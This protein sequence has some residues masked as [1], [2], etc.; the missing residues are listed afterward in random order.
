VLGI[1]TSRCIPA[2]KFSGWKI[3]GGIRETKSHG[4]E[5]E[6][7][8]SVIA[9]CGSYADAASPT[10]DV[11]GQIESSITAGPGLLRAGYLSGPGESPPPR[12]LNSS[13]H[14][15]ASIRSTIDYRT[16]SRS[17]LY[18]RLLGANAYGC[19]TLGC[20]AHASNTSAATAEWQSA[21]FG[22]FCES[23][24]Q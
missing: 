23:I 18:T 12:H 14:P 5:R 19:R 22:L 8:G 24:C 15:S 3:Y 16:R 7:T 20:R 13:H 10:S 11:R 21:A 1:T 9:S 4:K 2:K 17:G 6:L